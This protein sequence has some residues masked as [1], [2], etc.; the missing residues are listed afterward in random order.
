M[1]EVDPI[2]VGAATVAA[3]VFSGAYYAAVGDRLAE[4]SPAAAAGEN[5]GPLTLVAELVRS[6]VVA[7]VLA[8]Y[9]SLM[10]AESAGDGLLLGLS[11]WV[12]FPVVLLAGSV[13][14][15][16][17]APKLAALHAGDWL[18]KLVLIAV[19]VTVVG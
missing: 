8:G 2:A 13:L 3:F 7:A 19:I 14:H 15:E 6:V 16:K 12:G 10:D 9:A 18:A 17:V 1:L 11:A 4:L 5:P